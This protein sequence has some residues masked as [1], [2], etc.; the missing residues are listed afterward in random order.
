MVSSLTS[1]SYF[2]CP[3]HFPIPLYCVHHPL[4]LLPLD[5]GNFFHLDYFDSLLKDL[6]TSTTAPVQSL[7]HTRATAI[8]ANSKSDSEFSVQNPEMAFD[9]TKSRS[10]TSYSIILDPT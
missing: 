10:Q 1:L 3:I 6:P 7:P 8:H 4:P 2:P 9:F 5:L